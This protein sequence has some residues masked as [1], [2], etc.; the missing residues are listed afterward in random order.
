M[1]DPA[2][3]MDVQSIGDEMGLFGKKKLKFRT[4]GTMK[5]MT[6][7]CGY[8]GVMTGYHDDDIPGY[9]FDGLLRC[10]KCGGV[11]TGYPNGVFVTQKYQGNN[12][13]AYSDWYA[14]HYGDG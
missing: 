2:A 13:V 8:T 3:A 7:P 14:K 10:W 4:A 6:C 1:P 5:V 9:P 11:Y 12:R